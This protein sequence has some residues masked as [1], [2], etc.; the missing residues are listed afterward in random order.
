VKAVVQM[1]LEYRTL[2]NI[3]GDEGLINA[4]KN[5]LDFHQ[6]TAADC[7]G[8]PYDQV[9]KKQRKI[10]KKINFALVYGLSDVSLAED[11]G[12]PLK[13]ASALKQ[14]YFDSKPKVKE[15]IASTQKETLRDGFVRTMFGRI[16]YF[17]EL[18]H[19]ASLTNSQMESV[20]RRCFNTKIQ[21]SAADLAKIALYRIWKALR[22][23]GL[24]KDVKMV[25]QVHDEINFEV[26]KEVPLD[27]L[28]P[29]FDKALSF[30][31]IKPGFCDIPTSI[32]IGTCY[33]DT[34]EIEEL[35]SKEELYKLF[36]RRYKFEIQ[37]L[38]KEDKEALL[39][40]QEGHSEKIE[41]AYHLEQNS[42]ATSP[43]STFKS[44]SQLDQEVTDLDFQPKPNFMLLIIKTDVDQEKAFQALKSYCAQEFGTMQIVYSQDNMFFLA[45]DDFTVSGNN[46][47]SLEPFFIV[48]KNQTKP[49]ISIA[50]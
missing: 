28:L 23:T 11:L 29:I 15:L 13:E 35:Y 7:L 33:S 44:D 50:L 2:A 30:Y 8:I 43:Q 21:G 24:D 12:M 46:T 40:L 34:V 3:S 48:K 32:E 49:K 39:D 9:T 17:P 38:D 14:R 18:Q 6:Q 47:D 31:E 42:E 4:Y 36:P 1:Q 37:R 20:K 45:G 27:K 19:R 41:S 22:D 16:R 25:T 10:G 5:G 26:S